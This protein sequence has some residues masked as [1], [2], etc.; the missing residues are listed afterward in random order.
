MN[1]LFHIFSKKSAVGRWCLGLFLAAAVAFPGC[2]Q[3]GLND[4]GPHDDGLRRSDLALPARQA[5]A[6]ENPPSEKKPADDPLMSDEAQ[7]IYHDLD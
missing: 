3:L 5:R 2:K 7:R 6:N 4:D 1:L